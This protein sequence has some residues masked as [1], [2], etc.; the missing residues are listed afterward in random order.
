MP[1]LFFAGINLW[2]IVGVCIVGGITTIIVVVLLC[3]GCIWKRQ[4]C[5]HGDTDRLRQNEIS[6]EKNQ[7]RGAI[8]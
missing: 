6:L 1:I 8:S 2:V 3:V 7:Q 5:I 4:R